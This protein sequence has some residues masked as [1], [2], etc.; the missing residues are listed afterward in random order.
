MER[1]SGLMGVGAIL[2]AIM[3]AVVGPGWPR[4]WTG[5]AEAAVTR[6]VHAADP[7]CAGLHPCYHSIQAAVDAAQAGDTVQVQPGTYV[8]QISISGKNDRPGATEASRIVIQAHPAAPAGSVTLRGAGTRCARG[9]AIQVQRSRF[10][11]IRGLTVTGAGGPAVALLGGNN[12]NSGVRIE[13]NRIVDNGSAACTRGSGITIARGNIDVLVANNLIHGN[14][15]DGIAIADPDG[16]PHDVI[17]NTIH[18]N[19]GNGVSVARSRDVLLANN[20]ITRNGSGASHVG[21]SGKR[22]TR[23]NSGG[24]RLLHNV[25]CGNRSGEIAA[26]ALDGG[27]HGNRTPAGAEGPGVVAS[28]GCDVPTL[29]YADPRGV[30]GREGTAD[31]D[32]TPAPGSPLIDHGLDPR[33]LSFPDPTH[34]RLEADFVAEGARPRAGV[35]GGA[36]VFDVGA[37]EVVATGGALPV[38]AFLHPAAGAFVRGS[39]L[40]TAEGSSDDDIAALALRVDGHA[41]VADPVPPPPAPSITFVATW[42]TVAVADGLHTLAADA[43]DV[44]GNSTSVQHAVIVDNTPPD[45]G[46]VDGPMDTIAASTASFTYTGS[47]N[48]SDA[49]ALLYAWRLDAQPFGAYSAATTASLTGLGE[50]PHTFEVR[51]RDR[52]GNE[53][54]TPARRDFTVSSLLGVAIDDPSPGVTMQAGTLI[55]RGTIRGVT[56]DVGVLVNGVRAAVQAPGFVALVPVSTA[57]TTLVA[58]A[59]TPSGDTAAHSIPIIVST[60]TGQPATILA[61][62]PSGGP[63]PLAVAFSARA[64]GEIVSVNLDLDGNGTTDFTGAHLD[65]QTFTYTL[66]GLYTP[67]VTL[68]D[69]QGLT[70]T[71]STVVHVLD[72]T[73][74]DALL[75]ATWTDMKDALRSGDVPAALAY[76]SSR[77]RARYEQLFQVLGPRLAAIDSIL[78]DVTADELTATEAFYTMLRTDDGI[79]LVFEIRFAVDDDGLWRIHSF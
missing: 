63:A 23:Q 62:S 19:G 5:V 60:E 39:V 33:A 43:T 6:H 10:I 21:V 57:T 72:P 69:T 53:D 55:V 42:N 54:P 40:V 28:P 18:G 78:S 8:E 51:A 9:H 73:A 14:G 30:D 36:A 61:A 56:G 67:T 4:S 27:D 12:R 20:A 76:I 25:I 41:L 79:P 16:G 64:S 48:L 13:R 31:D 52:A 11:T 70:V 65:G 46:I 34:P 35:L 45:T 75:T 47:D 58:T 2:I 17:G 29:V 1:Q 59:R 24:V 26:S 15:R 3:V 22:R 37:I 38:V 44:A 32:F 77:N 71:A 7:A 66:P 68:T 50:G 49:L 74:L